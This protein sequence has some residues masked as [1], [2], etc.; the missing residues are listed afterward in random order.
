[1]HSRLALY[2]LRVVLCLTL[3]Y[4]SAWLSEHGQTATVICRRHLIGRGHLRKCWQKSMLI[5]FARY[6]IFEQNECRF[7]NI[8]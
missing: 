3:T 8:F 5:L 6:I 4:C 1:M 2:L 7:L